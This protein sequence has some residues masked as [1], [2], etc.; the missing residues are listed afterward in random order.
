[1]EELCCRVSYVTIKVRHVLPLK[2]LIVP[3]SKHDSGMTHLPYSPFESAAKSSVWIISVVTRARIPALGKVL[4][5]TD[6]E[7]TYG[8][9]AVFLQ[10]KTRT[11]REKLGIV[12]E[13][14]RI[15]QRILNL[16]GARAVEDKLVDGLEPVWVLIPPGPLHFNG[17]ARTNS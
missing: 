14:F 2:S 15:S 9:E 16:L 5:L 4:C 7:Q 13:R 8:R 1:M 6:W 12:L 11:R 10:R 17:R 3:I